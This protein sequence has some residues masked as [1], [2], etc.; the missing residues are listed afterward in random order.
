MRYGGHTSCLAIT[1]DG[2]AAPSL[3]LDCGTGVRGV[4]RELA[5]EPFRGAVLLTHLHWDHVQGVP[6]FRA[7][8]DERAR[9]ALLMP[10]QPDGAPAIDV[11]AGSMSPPHFPIGPRELRGSWSFS[12]L[13]EGEWEGEGFT[14]LAREVPHKGGRT[15]G[16]RVSD[17]RSTL[18]YIPDHGPTLGGMGPDGYGEYHDAAMELCADADLMV[19]DA[20][21]LSAE[22]LAAESSYGH[23]CADYAVALAR[24]ARARRVVLFHHRVDRT[25]D[26]LDRFA[27][28][29]ESDPQ[30][31]VAVQGTAFEL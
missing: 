28:A 18:A 6:F 26:E 29:Y 21:L 7:A 1:H 30:V 31:T 25:D 20:Q 11:L 15:F 14:V 24:R 27:A 2:A 5:G 9:V 16:Y 12:T 13:G 8:D 22:E 19:H 10:E 17:S 3:V 4:T 23:A